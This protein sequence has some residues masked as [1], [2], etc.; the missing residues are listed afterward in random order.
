MMKYIYITQL[1]VLVVFTSSYSQNN[2]IRGVVTDKYNKALANVKVS[3]KD[4][5]KGVLTNEKGEYKIEVAQ[6]CKKIIFTY[7]ELIFEEKIDKRKIVNRKM[8]NKNSDVLIEP[9]RFN[10]MLNGGGAVIFGAVS[11][12]FLLTKNISFDL[13]FGMFKPYV[14]TT[15]YINPLF[16][17]KKWQPYIGANVAYFEEF[18]G[19]TSWLLYIPVGIRFLNKKGTSLSFEVAGLMS[20]N[21]RFMIKSP[22]WGGIKFGKYF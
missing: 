6:K 2:T 20:D 9:Y 22:V 4:S 10:V 13:G 8:I 11:F 7:N 3:C 21:E 14:G 12:S 15:V 1:F 16:K 19:P 18:M 17:N 5:L